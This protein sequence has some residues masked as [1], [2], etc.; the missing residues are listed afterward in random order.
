MCD[1]RVGEDVVHFLM[2]CGELREIGRC[3]WMICAESREQTGG[4]MILES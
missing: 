3:C 4:W 1:S 2:G